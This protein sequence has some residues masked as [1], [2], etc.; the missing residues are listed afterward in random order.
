MLNHINLKIEKGMTVALVGPI[1][2]GKSTLINLIPRFFDAD[3]GQLLIDGVEI[4][5]IPLGILRKHIGIVHQE[6]FL[7]SDTIHDNVAY[8]FAGASEN[9]V[10]EALQVSQLKEDLADFPERLETMVGER[11]VTL[12]GGQKQRTAIA[13]AVVL[14]PKILILDDSLSAVDTHTEEEILKGLRGVMEE[15]TS[16][17]ISHRISTVKDADL[18][19]VLNEGKIA[20][21]GSH[22]ELLA[23]G[24]RY[25]DMFH[26]QQLQQEIEAEE[27]K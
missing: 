14:Q 8:G 4:K 21:R 17:I 2:A 16:I 23:L 18:I 7:F 3:E 11:G 1:G 19:V 26:K 13:R 25:A 20:E 9:E 24:G 27:T 5:T 22:D 10:E 15:R 12:S 6:T